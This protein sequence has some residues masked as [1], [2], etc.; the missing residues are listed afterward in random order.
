M[1]KLLVATHNAGKQI[2]FRELLADWPGEIVFPQD[3]GLKL[4]VEERGDSFREIAVL[5][6][7][8]YACA[9]G[10]PS[11]ADDSG[12]EVDALLGSPGVR[13][14][15]FAGEDAD[16]EANNRRLLAQLEGVP[17]TARGARF[18]CV[19]VC[20]RHPEDPAPIIREGVWEGRIGTR[21]AGTGGFG[22]DPLFLPSGS[23]RT[24]AELPPEEK[25][26]LSH[27][28]HALRK[29]VAALG[30]C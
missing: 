1:V 6:A 25:N 17:E 14:S 9:S 20:L 28:G 27:R 11:L 26:R 29:L 18:R 2:E 19:M 24:A 4:D 16:D 22:Y 7:R 13:S 30:A 21:P 15:R 8:A 23:D 12:L 3:L 10:L 5:K